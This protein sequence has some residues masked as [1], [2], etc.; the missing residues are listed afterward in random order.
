MTLRRRATGGHLYTMIADDEKTAP[1]KFKGHK[2]MDPFRALTWVVVFA[3]IGCILIVAAN[4]GID[5]I[6]MN[7]TQLV[8]YGTTM[9][10]TYHRM[11]SKV[12][13]LEGSLVS[14]EGVIAAKIGEITEKQGSIASKDGEIAT[15]RDGLSSKDVEITSLRANLAAKDVEITERSKWAKTD[16]SALQSRNNQLALQCADLQARCS[17]LERQLADK[18]AMCFHLVN[19]ESPRD[20]EKFAELYSNIRKLLHDVA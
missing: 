8:V 16:L 18:T 10:M 13:T 3:S 7:V 2:K 20:N 11:G 15:L 4:D 17:E 19:M 6:R 14:K 5:Y 1:A 9:I 12:R